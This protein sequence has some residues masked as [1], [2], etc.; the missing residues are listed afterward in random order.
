MPAFKSEDFP[1]PDAPRTTNGRR[2]R[3]G[4]HLA[5][6]F[7]RVGDLATSTKENPGISIIIAE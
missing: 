1:A 4:P 6:L 3:F 2:P 5:Q 7:E